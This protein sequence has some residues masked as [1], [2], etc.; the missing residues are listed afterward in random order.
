MSRLWRNVAS[1]L[2][3]N[4]HNQEDQEEAPEGGDCGGTPEEEGRRKS[5]GLGG[6][7]NSGGG[8]DFGTISM[9]MG[10]NR[11]PTMGGGTL[12]GSAGFE[13]S[14]EDGSTAR[15]SRRSSVL[16]DLFSLFR[17]SSSIGTRNLVRPHGQRHGENDDEYD[18]DEEEPQVM[19][20]EKL[21]E[22]IRQKKEIIGKLVRRG[23]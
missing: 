19:S 22:A 12:V 6:G 11:R 8:D 23:A 15:L 10:R 20:K 16:I 3:G 14:E 5:S 13:S 18:S 1:R 17:R 7:S 21:L 4:G 9:I 2:L